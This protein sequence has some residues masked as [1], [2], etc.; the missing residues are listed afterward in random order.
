M[1]SQIDLKKSN[2]GTKVVLLLA[3]FH[4]RVPFPIFLN[5]EFQFFY[6]SIKL[7]DLRFTELADEV[8]ICFDEQNNVVLNKNI[9][10]VLLFICNFSSECD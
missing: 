8:P 5:E 10:Y 9:F 6:G 7:H 1:I 2:F 4:R 3:L